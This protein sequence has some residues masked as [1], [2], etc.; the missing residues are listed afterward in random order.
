MEAILKIM[1]VQRSW[2]STWR[3]IPSTSRLTLIVSEPPLAALEED[4]PSPSLVEEQ[5]SLSAA[6]G[7]VYGVEYSLD[8]FNGIVEE[9][10]C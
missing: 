8:P 5:P 1:S 9:P 10:S 6:E 4:K 2:M 3:E 7:L